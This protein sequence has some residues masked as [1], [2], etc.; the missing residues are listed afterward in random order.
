MRLFEEML[1]ESQEE[2]ETQGRISSIAI[3][4]VKEN[5]EEKHP[6][7]VEKSLGSIFCR[8]SEVRLSWLSIWETSTVPLS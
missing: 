7:M 6:G 5:W 1:E 3:G 4:V 8:K 2:L